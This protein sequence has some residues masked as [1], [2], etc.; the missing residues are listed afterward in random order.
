MKIRARQR[1]GPTE[2]YSKKAAHR[3]DPLM[4]AYGYRLRAVGGPS[5]VRRT[6]HVEGAIM[7]SSSAT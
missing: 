3:P 2:Q 6:S 1:Y 4:L 7:Q 5:E